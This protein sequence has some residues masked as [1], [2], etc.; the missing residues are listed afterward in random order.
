MSMDI[1][2]YSKY[3]ENDFSISYIHFGL[4]IKIREKDALNKKRLIEYC[5]KQNNQSRLNQFFLTE[6]NYIFLSEEKKPVMTY[7]LFFSNRTRWSRFNEV[8]INDKN[9]CA[10]LMLISI[11]R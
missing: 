7:T 2:Y 3:I 8:V 5:K 10:C 9:L 1:E 4:S 6:Y 11:E